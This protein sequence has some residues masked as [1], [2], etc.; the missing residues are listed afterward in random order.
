MVI[1]MGM[2]RFFIS[3]II[4]TVVFLKRDIMMDMENFH[5]QKRVTLKEFLEKII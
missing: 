1:L 2:R 5:G 4:N 3:I